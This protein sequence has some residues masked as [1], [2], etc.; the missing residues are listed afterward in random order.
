M[1]LVFGSQSGALSAA[2]VPIPGAVA[3]AAVA[4][5]VFWWTEAACPGG[6]RRSGV[7]DD[8]VGARLTVPTASGG[9]EGLA[10][11][12]L[13]GTEVVGSVAAGPARLVELAA[14]W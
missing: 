2:A 12:T 11:A 13:T 1:R 7:V 5:A 14:T 4:V 6:R 3:A 10:S 9:D 8:T